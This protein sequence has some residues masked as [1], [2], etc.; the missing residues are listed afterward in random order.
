M[1]VA[2]FKTSPIPALTGEEMER[3]YEENA[4]SL[5]RFF[6]RRVSSPESAVDLV[7]ET[8]A[9]GW[10]SRSQARGQSAEERRAWLFG[11]ARHR[12][13]DFRRRGYA[14]QSAYSRLGLTRRSLTIDEFERIEQVASLGKLSGAVRAGFARLSE[15]DQE[16]LL[17]RIVEERDYPELAASLDVSETA[18][19]ARVSRAL[20]RLRRL[21]DYSDDLEGLNA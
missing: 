21:G 7:A 19:R 13:A 6:A 10:Q 18:A 9:A 20:A 5:L 2:R 8:F 11:I 12:L 1:G 15:S 14:E 4:P 17:L 16:V 3:M